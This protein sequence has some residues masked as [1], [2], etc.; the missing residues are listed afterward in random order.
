MS[1]LGGGDKLARG[2]Q[3]AQFA[4]GASTLSSFEDDLIFRPEI[5]AEKYGLSQIEIDRYQKQ[6]G[7]G[8]K[9]PDLL[10][11][12][13]REELSSIPLNV[14]DKRHS[15]LDASHPL[16]KDSKA[17]VKPRKFAEKE[18]ESPVCLL[19][20]VLVYRI[21]DDPDIELLEDGTQ[22]RKSTGFIIPP[23]YRQHSNVGIVIAVGEVVVLG[24]VTFDLGRFVKVGDKVTF[25]DYNSE[26][27]PMDPHKAQ[28]LCDAVEVD[29]EE[30]LE[31]IRVIRVQDIR[32]NE[33][34]RKREVHFDR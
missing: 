5:V 22:R 29:Y 19:D 24:G 10:S 17:A 14:V 1:G 13:D 12:A 6:R 7:E 28:A 3:T 30:N 8:I 33:H 9:M 20:R 34:P 11:V 23:E 4:G 27:F 32:V 26:M 15:Y 16:A 31:N 18:Y 2:A 21:T 25:G